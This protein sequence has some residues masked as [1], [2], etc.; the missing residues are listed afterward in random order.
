MMRKL[1]LLACTCF[2]L[3][4]SV[5][6]KN[7]KYEFAEF[8]S[9]IKRQI[10][11]LAGKVE[12]NQIN[13]QD[14]RD[15]FDLETKQGKLHIGASSKSAA[16]QAINWYLKHYAN[17]MLS[18]SGDNIKALKKIPEV[19]VKESHSSWA[20]V[21]FAL[22]YCTHN[23]TMS[24]WGWKEWEKELD[25][26]ALNGINVSLSIVG[27]EQ[28]WHNVLKK[29]SFTDS[30]I[31]AFIP[32]PAYTAWWLMGNLEGWGGP[33]PAS[34]REDRVVLQQKIIKRMR[35]L[36]IE[37]ELHGFYGMV[38]RI[39][40]AKMPEA[41]IVDQGV[42]AGGF[43]RPAF[44][45]PSDPL[46]EKI[47]DLYYSE[48]KKLYG[49]DIKYFGGDPFHEG[50]TSGGINV[51]AAGERIQQLMQK[52]YPASTW[53]L[54]GWGGNPQQALLAGLDKKYIMVQDLFG[55]SRQVWEDQQAYGGT[56]FIWSIVSNF[57]GTEGMYGKLDRILNEPQRAASKYP[58]SFVGIGATPEG[59]TDNP[60][61]YDLVF[62]VPWLPAP[63]NIASF[64]KQYPQYRYGAYST[65]TEKAWNIF[66]ETVYYSDGKAQEG[67]TESILCARPSLDIKSVSTW[68]TSHIPYDV[69]KFEVGVKHLL[70]AAPEFEAV[71][72]FRFDLID[73][74]RQVVANK[75]QFF[76]GKMKS[77]YESKDAPAY[78]SAS[79]SFLKLIL[80]Q[81]QLL[82]GDSRFMLSTW[83]NQ[84][85][86]LG[87]DKQ[88][89]DLAELNAKTLIT[90]WGPGNNPQTNLHEYS[91]REWNGILGTLYY[92]RWKLFVGQQQAFLEGKINEDTPI[93]FF[94]MESK[95]ANELG[96]QY[97]SKPVTDYV[98]MAREIYQQVL[99]M[100]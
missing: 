92:D 97:K 52:H 89:K 45:D 99:A 2:V 27:V 100:Q 8:Q 79:A 95:W 40:K 66:L 65:S 55:E 53:M 17:Q 34:M 86:S 59:I 71:P 38:P 60:V 36:G 32:G 78:K 83:I 63:S 80:L 56:P 35:E 88:A 19:K 54:M 49:K 58:N 74:V 21:R 22:N 47:G 94:T 16:G 24:F 96:Q 25:W 90:I 41:N 37:P 77:S 84:A 15:V 44:L 70:D 81:D 29:M 10:P 73:A 98:S 69:T 46:F 4:L 31:D 72:S 30:E 20:D 1:S 3:L 68:G 43:D 14:G 87:R 93:D 76:H 85:R 9:L 12:F 33:M 13:K 23:Y 5:H 51:T 61:L 50:G 75:S 6:G 91:H 82:S 62:T 7:A 67:G 18:H 64:I 28:V 48:M 57:G 42:W 39:L 26:M 11:W